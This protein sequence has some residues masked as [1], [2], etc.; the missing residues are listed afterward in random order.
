MFRKEEF[1]K[2][3]AAGIS[4]RRNTPNWSMGLSLFLGRNLPKKLVQINLLAIDQ[5]PLI[6]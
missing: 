5:S 1:E 4:S 2:M 3:L 6:P